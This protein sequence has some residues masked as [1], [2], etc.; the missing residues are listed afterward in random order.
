MLAVLLATAV[1]LVTGLGGDDA[2]DP[3]EATYDP[4][5]GALSFTLEGFDGTLLRSQDLRGTPAV[6]NGYA[7][8][9]ALCLRE[10]PDFER[11]HLAAGSQV[12]VVG[13]NPQS[14][15]SDSAQARMVADTGI[16]Y[17]TVRDPDDRLLRHFSPTGGLPVTLFVDEDGVVRKVHRGVLTEQML[18]DELREVL[19]V[20]L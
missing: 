18:R 20:R 19:G 16:T 7:S 15:D 12:A 17:P 1:A 8:W 4:D 9:C 11:V 14:N 3:S 13:F 2:D 6:L 10:M 5:S